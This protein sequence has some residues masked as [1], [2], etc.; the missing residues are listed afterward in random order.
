MPAAHLAGKKLFTLG[1]SKGSGAPTG[2]F[3]V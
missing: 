1:D 2:T 3:P